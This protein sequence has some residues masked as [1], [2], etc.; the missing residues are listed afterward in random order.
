MKNFLIGLC[1]LG[2]TSSVFAQDVLFTAKVKEEK[3]PEVLVTSVKKDF[4]DYSVTEYDAIP[5]TLVEDNVIIDKNKFS[6]DYDE[7]YDTFVVSLRGKNGYIDA[8]YDAN[9]KLISTSERMKDSE[10]PMAVSQSVVKNFPG[11]SIIKD[12]YLTTHNLQDGKQ[13]KH[14]RVEIEKDHKKSHRF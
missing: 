14:Y 10:L 11:W 1:F 2:L 12:V 5:I 13:R 9:G 3:V 6:D 8:T 7:D 4:K